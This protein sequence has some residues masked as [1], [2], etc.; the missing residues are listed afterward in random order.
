MNNETMTTKARPAFNGDPSTGVT[1]KQKAEILRDIWIAHDGRWFIKTASEHGFDVATKL[2]LAVQKPFG[3][4]EMKRLM[5]ALGG[6]EVKNIEDLHRFLVVASDVYCPVEHKYAYTIIDENNLSVK[7]LQ[8]YVHYNVSLAGTTE[9]HKC[10]GKTRF[11][12]WLKGLGLDGEIINPAETATC[13][14]QCEF[15]FKI[16]W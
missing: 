5:K 15:F 16:N 13:G 3:K 4:T 11:E 14:G 12:A 9:I 1:D 8:C 6:A 10:A 2:N 7:I